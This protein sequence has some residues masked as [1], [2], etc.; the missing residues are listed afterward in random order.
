MWR[1]R[2]KRKIIKINKNQ[3]YDNS[4]IKRVDISSIILIL[5]TISGKFWKREN[6]LNFYK[7]LKKKSL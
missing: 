7:N 6:V 3:T 1:V 5:R 2:N 4:T